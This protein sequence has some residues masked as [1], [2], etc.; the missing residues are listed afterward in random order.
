MKEQMEN[1][2]HWKGNAL[3]VDLSVGVTSVPVEFSS[4]LDI[5]LEKASLRVFCSVP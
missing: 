3:S 1:K 5:K 2:N 4:L